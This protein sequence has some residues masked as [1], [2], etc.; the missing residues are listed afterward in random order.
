[1]DNLNLFLF[2]SGT[3]SEHSYT[4]PTATP[5]RVLPTQKHPVPAC[6]F[7]MAFYSATSFQAPCATV[8]TIRGVWDTSTQGANLIV[9]TE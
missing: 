3:Y 9:H 5:Q 8:L 7:S 1:M 2:V 4:G 6:H